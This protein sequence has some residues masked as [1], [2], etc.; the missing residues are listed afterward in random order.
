MAYFISN[1]VYN[2]HLFVFGRVGVVW[3]FLSLG[4][5]EFYLLGYRSTK[6]LQPWLYTCYL[7]TVMFWNSS[8]HQILEK[9][10]VEFVIFDSSENKKL[11]A[12]IIICS[13]LLL[14]LNTFRCIGVECKHIKLIIKFGFSFKCFI[15]HCFLIPI[16]RSLICYYDP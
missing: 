16:S 5:L 13:T 14:F 1:Y 3:S 12:A 2:V 6:V 15:P 9:I 7:I 11:I 10:V 8:M 4:H